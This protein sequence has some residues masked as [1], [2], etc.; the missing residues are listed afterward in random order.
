MSSSSRWII[1]SNRLPYQYN[2][3]TNSLDL[4]SGGLV[5]AITGIHSASQKIWLGAVLEDE[6]PHWQNVDRPDTTNLSYDMVVVNNDE[7]DSY[8]NGFCNDVLWPAFHYQSERVQFR[9]D[10]WENYQ[11]VN[12]LFAE[13]IN[14]I[15]KPND[16][17]WIH[18]FQLALVP[19]YLKELNPELTIGWFLHVPFPSSELYLEIPVRNEILDGILASDLVGF[20]DYSYVRHFCSSVQRVFGIETSLFS[21]NYNH[22]QVSI[23]VFPVSIDFNRF[24]DAAQIPGVVKKAK[25]YRNTDFLFLGVDRL[26]YSKGVDLKIKAYYHFLLEH[27]ELHG[28]VSLIQ[29]AVPTRQDV[30]EYVKLRLDIE[31]LVSEVNG[32]FATPAWAPIHY[33]FHP[34]SFEELMALY[35]AADCLVV[36]SKRDGMNL[37]SLEYVAAQSLS[38]PGIVLI[39]EFTGAKSLLSQAIPINPRDV[40]GTAKKMFQAF[41]MSQSDR[42]HACQVMM[43]YLRNYTATDWAKA[44]IT[45]LTDVVAKGQRH[46]IRYI[47][48]S[49]AFVHEY[50][51]Q[52]KPSK[53]LLFIDYDGTL[54]K[55]R[56]NPEDAVLDES[57]RSVLKKLS[58]LPN[59]DVVVISGRDQ[60]FLSEQLQ[61]IDVYLAAE[62]GALFFDK[63]SWKNLSLSDST[64]WYG[65]T[66]QI[67]R[68]YTKQVPSSFIEQKNYCLC[69]HYRKSPSEF[70]EYQ[71]L[72]LHEELENGL[73]QFPA[74]L[75]HGKKVIEVCAMEANKGVFVRW[76]LENHADSEFGF[77]LG[78]DR[79]DED[80]FSE[81]LDSSFE[82][83]K[84]GLGP[85]LAKSRLSAQT[86]VLELL[87]C[88]LRQFDMLGVGE[89]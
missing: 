37:V 8:Y 34:V 65:N 42:Q 62:H 2:A 27:P 88:F 85:T 28:K 22:H 89:G 59:V 87:D 38:D 71:A 24:H 15:A 69:W 77:A 51:E 25:E 58:E 19:K 9:H 14:E 76:F 7:Y 74:R 63:K 16:L 5:T 6:L 17:I 11:R 43:E 70:A 29:V 20:H 32:R 81:L 47:K 48:D 30:D 64:K 36:T 23:G 60:F 12:R 55:I 78:D 57:D 52:Y 4:S 44:F 83:I 46:K 82:T 45:K 67:M 49:R 21:I 26:D 50:M 79:T 31:Q 72:K 53:I 35:R 39:S 3:E 41:E 80:I 10:D 40:E 18:D 66:L 33:L 86:A 61:G 84:V 56:K 73:S 54:V 13:K 1:V 75:I 68:D